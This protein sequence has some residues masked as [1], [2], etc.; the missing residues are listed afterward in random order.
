MCR[1]KLSQSFVKVTELQ[2]SPHQIG[3][4]TIENETEDI[5]GTIVLYAKA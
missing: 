2:G 5:L 4:T 3:N 1:L